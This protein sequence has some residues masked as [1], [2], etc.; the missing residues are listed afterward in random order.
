MQKVIYLKLKC[1]AFRNN[2]NKILY[3]SQEI[4]I[5]EKTKLWYVTI[6]ELDA[7]KKL[8]ITLR[9]FAQNCYNKIVTKNDQMLHILH[10]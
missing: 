1:Y 4:E 10:E 2:N 7:K 6:A 9:A 3:F 5:I 8:Q